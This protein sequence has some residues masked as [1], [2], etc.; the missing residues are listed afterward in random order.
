MRVVVL[1]VVVALASCHSWRSGWSG[2]RSCREVTQP[3]SRP[4]APPV[5]PPAHPDFTRLLAHRNYY[6]VGRIGE[7]E[8]HFA[9]WYNCVEQSVSEYAV[10]ADGTIR[11]AG[12][13]WGGLAVRASD[14][15]PRIPAA[16]RERAARVLARNDARHEGESGAVVAYLGTYREVEIH[17]RVPRSPPGDPYRRMMSHATL[18]LRADADLATFDGASDLSGGDTRLCWKDVVYGDCSAAYWFDF[19]PAIGAGTPQLPA[20][21]DPDSP[22]STAERERFGAAA[23]AAA[24]AKLAGTPRTTIDDSDASLLPAGFAPPVVVAF[25]IYGRV[26][27]GEQPQASL[28]IEIPS[29]AIARGTSRGTARATVGGVTITGEADVA[30]VRPLPAD[31]TG[32]QTF[33][34]RI[35]Y[36]LADDR[37]NTRAGELVASATAMIDGDS[38]VFTA[39]RLADDH[40]QKI[41]DPPNKQA[42]PGTAAL[43]SIDAY[44]GVRDR[45]ETWYPKRGKP[46]RSTTTP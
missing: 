22:Q 28:E 23:L 36:R 9:V 5:I 37:G 44:V 11:D 3:G 43:V 4:A 31:A 15:T 25:T 40:V 19:V 21:V 6:A 12:G 30:A 33:D 18:V 2:A 32:E 10:R 35:A 27:R 46:H 16:Q 7:Y 45:P 13:A 14:E 42:F 39:L 1:T 34:V 26:E 24:R 8:H 41:H 20:L 29:A 17:E 38:I